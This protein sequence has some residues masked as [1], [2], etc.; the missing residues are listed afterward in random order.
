MNEAPKNP[1]GI[2]SISGVSNLTTIE[3]L[4]KYTDNSILLRMHQTIADKINVK[5]KM[6]N[7]KNK[8]SPGAVSLREI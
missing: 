3:H 1:K 4:I 7:P 5:I 8:Y 6:K 2:Q